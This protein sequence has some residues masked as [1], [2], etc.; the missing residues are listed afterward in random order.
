MD[1]RIV[2]LR[3][4]TFDPN[5]PRRTKARA[6]QDAQL[7]A[8]IK[9]VGALQP[10][11]ARPHADGGL[12]VVAGER[13]V[14]CAIAAGLVEDFVLV[15]GPDDGGD[16]VRALSEN[17]MRQAMSAVDRG[18]VKTRRSGSVNSDLGRLG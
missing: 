18:C 11:V 17:V 10:P 3:T 16:A 15:R 13:R 5:N 14:K 8:N 9:R 2:D 1:L 6:E 12:V 7:T 4:L